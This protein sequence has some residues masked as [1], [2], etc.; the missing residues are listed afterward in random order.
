MIKHNRLLQ[1]FIDNAD[2]VIHNAESPQDLL[3]LIEEARFF[4]GRFKFDQRDYYFYFALDMIA[5]VSGFLLLLETSE[6]FW[7][8]LTGLSIIAGFILISRFLRRRKDANA[9]SQKI[10]YQDLL[11]D[12]NLTADHQLKF[13]ITELNA[14]FTEFDRGNHSREIRSVLQGAHIGALKTFP[15]HYYHFHYVDEHITEELDKEGKKTT[16]SVLEHHDR[17]GFIVTLE[18]FQRQS[19]TA[20]ESSYEESKTKPRL[21][22]QRKGGQMD[23]SFRKHFDANQNDYLPASLE[24]RDRFRVTAHNAFM[25]AKFLK[26]TVVERLLSMRESL[27]EIF[28]EINHH[29]ELLIAFNN[30][31][32]RTPK[33]QYDLNNID[34]F[35]AEIQEKTTI[36]EFQNTLLHIET[37]LSQTDNNF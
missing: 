15:F 23:R 12:N 20:L 25:A 2:S 30:D 36:P 7:L 34:A 31:F 6:G 29:N 28:L 14:R 27:G 9:I 22:I 17:F 5:F 24:F 16:K 3:D 11:F 21:I 4:K 10:F 26:P 32:L 13:S 33:S 18:D 19:S 1:A 8:F 35:L 37:L